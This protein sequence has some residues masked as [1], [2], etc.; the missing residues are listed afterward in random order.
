M[1][2][3]TMKAERIIESVVH[4]SIQICQQ[5]LHIKF[6]RYFDGK[7]HLKHSLVRVLGIVFL[8]ITGKSHFISSNDA[9]SG[10]DLEHFVHKKWNQFHSHKVG[11]KYWNWKLRK[12]WLDLDGPSL[13]KY[14]LVSHLGCHPLWKKSNYHRT[15]DLDQRVKMS[16]IK[17]TNNLGLFVSW[18][19]WIWNIPLGKMKNMSVEPSTSML[20]QKLQ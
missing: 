7:C 1:I 12:R 13:I 5:I 18:C 14:Y 6:P 9:F 16:K 10:K 17:I 15:W 3:V 11:T 20:E 4:K 8:S 19:W 2:E